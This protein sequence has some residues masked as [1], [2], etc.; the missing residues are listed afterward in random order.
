MP[1]PVPFRNDL[2][3]V[4]DWW[5]R[6][7]QRMAWETDSANSGDVSTEY[8]LATYTIPKNT[9]GS[10]INPNVT[11]IA[12]GQQYNFHAEALILNNSGGTINYTQ[13]VKVNGTTSI[14]TSTMAIAPSAGEHIAEWDWRLYIDT[15]FSLNQ[16]C[17]F[18][19]SGI[20]APPTATDDLFFRTGYTRGNSI[21]EADWASDIVLTITGQWASTTTVATQM[22]QYWVDRWLTYPG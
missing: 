13:R 1:T 12:G 16:R 19:V 21:V 8:T 9:F 15:D 5:R 7:P 17:Q 14:G 4:S 3:Y 2:R 6:I 10:A 22:H 20:L 18:R 11:Y